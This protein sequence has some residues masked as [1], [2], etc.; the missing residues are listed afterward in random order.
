MRVVLQFAK[1][2]TTMAPPRY[3]KEISEAKA[4][5]ILRALGGSGFDRLHHE[6]APLP[7]CDED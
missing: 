7:L 3:A 5:V 1:S 4:F 2:L 6:T